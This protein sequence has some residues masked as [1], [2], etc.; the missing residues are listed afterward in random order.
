M[1]P[2]PVEDTVL[3]TLDYLKVK[4]IAANGTVV[5]TGPRFPVLPDMF[6]TAEPVQV[7]VEAGEASVRLIPTDAGVFQVQEFLDGAPTHTWHIN[8]PTS[9]E[10][11]TR[12]LFSFA[13]VQPPVQ[14]VTVN[15]FL[16]GVGAP[17]NALG[18]DGDFY[19]DTAAKFWYGPKANAAWPAGFSVI[20]PEGPEGDQGP[21]GN[22]GPTGPMGSAGLFT[23]LRYYASPS[24]ARTTA[25]VADGVACAHPFWVGQTTTFERIGAE[26]TTAVAASAVRLGV[27]ADTGR[28]SPGARILDA[29]TIDSTTTGAKEITIST[30]LQPGLYWLTTVAQGGAPTMRAHNG[31]LFPVGAGSLAAATGAGGIFT[32][33]LT[34]ATVSGAL[35]ATYPA[36]ANYQAFSP[37]V[38]LKAS[39]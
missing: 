3:I 20:G 33:V 5:F 1:A 36:V 30:T 38:A 4:N 27:Y 2:V 9:L 25:S 37:L 16:S 28:G 29:G 19:Y 13:P 17:S 12:S 34:A 26:V 7:A 8:I 39:A 35:P 18:I 10:G 22:V 31:T 6:V 15:T 32:G 21:Q 14:G 24:S 23:G 11:Q